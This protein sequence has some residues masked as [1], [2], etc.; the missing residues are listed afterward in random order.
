MG[1]GHP[2]Q[3]VPEEYKAYCSVESEKRAYIVQSLKNVFLRKLRL[4]FL[5][6]IKMKKIHISALHIPVW[7]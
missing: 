4:K 6:D 7:L 5:E 2:Y 1:S 3:H